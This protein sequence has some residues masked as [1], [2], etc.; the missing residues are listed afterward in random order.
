[1]GED[2]HS[3]TGQPGLLTLPPVARPG[4]PWPGPATHRAPTTTGRYRLVRRRPPVDVP[5]LDADQRRVT[6]HAAGPLL[7][8]AGPGTGKTTTLV[9]AVVARIE[10][11]ADPE[12][13]LVLTFGRRA[14]NRLRERIT[15]RLGRTTT[16]PLARTFHSYAW[17]LLRRDAAGRGERAPRLLTGPEQDAL[18][19]ELLGGDVE[20]IGVQWPEDRLAA[21]EAPRGFAAELRDL[22]LRAA[23]RGLDPVELDHLGALHR[24]PDW[25]AAA[26]FMQQYFDVVELRDA[27]SPTHGVGYDNALIIQEAVAL[28]QRDETLLADERRARGYVF[29]DEYQETDPAQRALLQ[30]LCGG[31]RFLVAAGD[32]DQS[33]FAFRGASV[34]GMR[35]FAE[36]FPTAQRRPAPTVV[37][38]TA[39]RAEPALM[40]AAERVAARLRGSP[41]HR[42]PRPAPHRAHEPAITGDSGVDVATFRSATQE[43]SYVAH[44]LRRA[45]LLGGVPWSQMAVIVRSTDVSAGTLRRA[46]VQA[47][48]PVEVATEELPL[49]R[50][51]GIA[52]LVRAL[53]CGLH[54]ERLDEENA[55]A[56]LL[57]S[58]GGADALTLRRL[59][60][61][62]RLVAS[63]GGD[64]RPSG[65]L[66]AEA[67][68]DPAEL[69]PIE[70]RWG[71]AAR[72][73][74]GVLAAIREAAAEPN[75]T[76]ESVLWAA[77]DSSGLSSRWQN[78]SLDAGVRG[79]DADHALDAAVALFD[80]AA[81]FVDDLPG[82]TPA[83]FVDYLEHLTI[84]ADSISA[85]AE[86]SE[87]VKILTAHAAKGLEWEI[88]AVAGVQEGLW[89]DLRPRG[90][91]LGSEQ[92]V[93]V[94]ADRT[95]EPAAVL[96]ALLEEERRL[97]YTAVT[98]A[99]AALVVTAVDG[100]DGEE[101]QQPSR[102]L[103][104]IDPPVGAGPTATVTRE[105][106]YVPRTLTLGGLV[107][108]LRT[109]VL[110]R[111]GDP[112]RRRA[113]ARQL[114]ELADNGVPGAD[115]AE[116]WGFL[117]LS[118]AGALR[119][120]GEM[121]RVSPSKVESFDACALRWLLESSGGA[122][123][124]QAQSIGSVVH[125]VAADVSEGFTEEDAPSPE[126]PLSVP[127]LAALSAR[128]AERWKRVDIGG[129]YGV[130]QRAR[131]EK[132]VER[133][134]DWLADNPRRLVAVE[135][136]FTVEVGRA[137]VRGRVD[138]LERDAEGRLVVVDLKTGKTKP[139]KGDLPLLP[140][141]GV[142]QL[143][144]ER[145][146][147]VQHGTVSGG[148]SLLQIGGGTVRSDEQV[149]PPLAD[150]PDP[151]WAEKLVHD[152]ADGMAG[153]AFHATQNNFCRMCPVSSSCPVQTEQVPNGD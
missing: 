89:P 138:R 123:T 129:W 65:V 39:H 152:V 127:D 144:V 139:G 86:R 150:L 122:T 28:L 44:R 14:A 153:S 48:V 137:T 91:V 63:A 52:P 15:E 38:G 135:R 120:P 6:E 133:L 96:T 104:E 118:D 70:A 46:L 131:A 79:A 20:G 51:P 43:A 50:Q 94:V 92:L 149:Q 22:L 4:A 45:H 72:R 11:G 71:R 41:L 24:R 143:A 56:L 109:V 111:D 121:V 2:E 77:W 142:Y 116:W 117:P 75:A 140:Q 12:S 27:Q 62:L 37:L 134:A 74:A 95:S 54:P 59:R 8:L 136:E 25:Q 105:T 145:A 7:V 29:V 107:A 5:V 31:G 90:S 78:L 19:R 73:V 34:E 30:L 113:A 42:T 10:V 16:E 108:E 85:T 114:A 110:D 58:L 98:R 82:S 101:G 64:M 69:V 57:S 126:A 103:D 99:R 18:F 3:G 88:V 132:M 49:P 32:P 81:R 80:Q 26:R 87:V 66:L 84:A 112:V 76:P 17:G 141:L 36:E 40:A 61:E 106:R 125:D 148:A 128:L 151:R 55:V 93:D 35:D 21:L 60:Q 67:L 146:G 53:S 23:E 83:L 115:P 124:G 47:G 100:V 97:F 68:A 1:V 13:I 33:I 147:F 102:F 119:G 9:E 130:K